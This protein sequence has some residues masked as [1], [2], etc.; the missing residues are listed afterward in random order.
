MPKRHNKKSRNG[1]TFYN[2][3]S[4]TKNKTDNIVGK[5]DGKEINLLIEKFKLVNPSYERLF[6]NTT[7]RAVL[8]RM[9]KKYGFEKLGRMINALP[10][11]VNQKFAPTITT[12]LALED[13]LGNLLAF[14][15][16]NNKKTGG[17]HKV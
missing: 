13:K 4:N 10:E 1:T 16:N 8:E 7:Q 17:V 14:I 12:P 3:E 9:S 2:T 11:I 15:S 5:A 6:K